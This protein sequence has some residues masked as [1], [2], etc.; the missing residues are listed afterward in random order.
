MGGSG[1]PAL[2]PE[3]RQPPPGALDGVMPA[4][5]PTRSRARIWPSTPPPNVGMK[6]ESTAQRLIPLGKAA[7]APAVRYGETSVAPAKYHLARR[8]TQ[9]AETSFSGN[10]V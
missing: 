5:A 2:V 3:S 9:N 8:P 10:H 6:P 4:Q 1:S 7:P